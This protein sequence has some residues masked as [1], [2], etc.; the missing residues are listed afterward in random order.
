MMFISRPIQSSVIRIGLHLI[1]PVCPV[2]SLYSRCS[3]LD[4]IPFVRHPLR[5]A[6]FFICP[7]MIR[8]AINR[9]VEAVDSGEWLS[10]AFLPS[11]LPL[12]TV[13]LSC[14]SVVQST[15]W[16]SRPTPTGR[17]CCLAVWPNPDTR[18]ASSAGVSW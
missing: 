14:S 8:D 7:L 1:V 9:E 17:R 18:W 10:P 6:Q 3:V 15:S 4:A 11:F 12:I 2:S 16:L 5:W 13:V